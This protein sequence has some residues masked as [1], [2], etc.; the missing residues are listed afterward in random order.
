ML[1]RSQTIP[2]TIFLVPGYGAQGGSAA[3]TAATFRD[4]G[5][6][7]VINSSRG[8]IA[9]F[10]PDDPQWEQAIESATKSAIADLVKSTPMGILAAGA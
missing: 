3:D 1:F 4:D 2:Q 10:K 5:L 6:G 8:I 7:A 9:C